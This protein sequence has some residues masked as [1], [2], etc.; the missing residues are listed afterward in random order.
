MSTIQDIDAL[1]NAMSTFGVQNEG[2]VGLDV[3]E[4]NLNTSVVLAAV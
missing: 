1:V 3:S 4:Q 2:L